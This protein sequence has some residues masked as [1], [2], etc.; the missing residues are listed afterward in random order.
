[1]SA[2]SDRLVEQFTGEKSPLVKQMAQWNEIS[3]LSLEAENLRD[4]L[5]EAR[6]RAAELWQTVKDQA[7]EIEF[8]RR[9]NASLR[10]AVKS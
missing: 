10:E 8:L 4:E 6:I 5:A 9:E 3:S 2:P 1:M 7:T